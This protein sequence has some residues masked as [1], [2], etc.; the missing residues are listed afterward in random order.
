MNLTR[1]QLIK[2]L[3]YDPDTGS[4]LWRKRGRWVVS[5]GYMGEQGRKTFN[6]KFPGRVAL[7]SICSVGYR[8]GSIF[9]RSLYAHRVI[10]VMIYGN[11]PI[12]Q[13]DHINR[14]RTDNRLLNLRDVSHKQNGRNQ[15]LREGNTTGVHGV[16]WLKKRE[17]WLA[18]IGVD[19]R[20]IFLGHFEKVDDAICARIEA[21]KQYW[22]M[23]LR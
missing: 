11:E 17:R 7:N 13:I 5:D 6:R 1:S 21:E 16:Y 14:D 23:R 9:Q 4:L 19:G 20:T 8:H 15:K 3:D 22:S 2:L 18:S 10:W 12:G